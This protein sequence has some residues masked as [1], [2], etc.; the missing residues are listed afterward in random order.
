MTPLRTAVVLAAA[1]TALTTAGCSSKKAS[2]DKDEVAESDPVSGGATTTSAAPAKPKPRPTLD[3]RDASASDPKS[4]DLGCVG[5]AGGVRVDEK[6]N[7]VLAFKSADGD[8]IQIGDQQAKVHDGEA[9][10]TVSTLPFLAKAPL[11]KIH[12]GVVIPITITPA[13]AEF[14]KLEATIK[15]DGE[16]LLV[17]TYKAA[18]K[19]PL[20]FPGD[21]AAPAK[22]HAMGIWYYKQPELLGNAATLADIDLVALE[23]FDT[24]TVGS[25]SYGRADGSAHVV[26]LMQNDRV[27]KIYDRRTGKLK[28]ER[29]FVAPPVTCSPSIEAS[30]SSVDSFADRD[31][32]MTW[33]NTLIEIVPLSDA[34]DA[35]A[36]AGASASA[37]AIE[38]DAPPAATTAAAQPTA[39][40]TQQVAAWSP[41]PVTAAPP[42]SPTPTPTP[43]ARRPR[44]PML[45]K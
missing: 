7:V 10:L 31:A 6:L 35:V 42:P 32:V 45:R 22:P 20:T 36:A 23:S 34:P 8:T 13:S 39:G 41:P 27:D 16:K 14:D 37:S 17:A 3:V 40:P 25:C 21:K 43:T 11:A 4:T 18:D 15:L 5:C 2:A 12:E 44:I 24:R 1:L 33:R 9:K 28:T 26:P 30:D 19:L 38:A 29:R